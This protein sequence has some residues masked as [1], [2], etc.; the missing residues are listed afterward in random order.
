[1]SGGFH[2]AQAN[3]AE[4]RFRLGSPEM[5]DFEAE[6]TTVNKLADDSPGFVWRKVFDYRGGDRPVIFGRDDYLFTLSVWE[7]IESLHSFTYGGKHLEMLSQRVKWF[8]KDE[9]PTTVLWWIDAG[10]I[11]DTQEAEQ[12]MAHVRDHGHS[13]YAFTFRH[14][15]RPEEERSGT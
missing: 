10:T 1:M 8:L 14:R 9:R 15:Y 2:L 7:D 3:M 5:A 12:R 11:P 6:L 4:L 13:P